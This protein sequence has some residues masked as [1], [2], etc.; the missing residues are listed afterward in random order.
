MQ[1][2]FADKEAVAERQER[3]PGDIRSTMEGSEIS[4][5]AGHSRWVIER[6]PALS[7]KRAPFDGQ[8]WQGHV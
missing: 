8:F 5:P 1:S 6:N 3:D 2:T 4:A 7:Q